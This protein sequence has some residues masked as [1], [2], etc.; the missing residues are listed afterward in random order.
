MDNSINNDATTGLARAESGLAQRPREGNNGQDPA[1]QAAPP[2]SDEVEL[3]PAGLE[4]SSRPERSER[5]PAP[6]NP[7]EAAALA[8]QTRDQIAQSPAQA[9]MAQGSNPSERVTDLLTSP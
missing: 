6:E 1:T 9:A 5:A 4:R 8:S 7:E 2:A 3:S